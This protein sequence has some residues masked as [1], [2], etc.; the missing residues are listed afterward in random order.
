MKVAKSQKVRGLSGRRAGEK[1]ERRAGY[2]L[3]VT[4]H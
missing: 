4:P 3:V 1:R 2:R